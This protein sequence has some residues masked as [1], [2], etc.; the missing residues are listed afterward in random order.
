MEIT[1]AAGMNA[2]LLGF[3]YR[4]L[5]GNQTLRLRVTSGDQAGLV[6]QTDSTMADFSRTWVDLGPYSG[7]QITLIWELYGP[8]GGTASVA[9]IDDIIIGDVPVLP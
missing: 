6:W 9:Q 3:K 4:L 7:R 8:K 2:P 1:L 5:E